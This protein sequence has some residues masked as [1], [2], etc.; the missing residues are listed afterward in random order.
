MKELI[1]K[2]VEKADLSEEQAAK[3]AEVVKDFL[4]DKL[5][6]AIKGPV[7]GALTGENIDHGVDMA[8]GLLGKLF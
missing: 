8:T 1:G 4:G 7:M 5:P 2:L 6:E 3:V